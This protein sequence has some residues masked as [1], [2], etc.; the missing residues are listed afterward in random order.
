MVFFGLRLLTWMVA[1]GLAALVAASAQA[2]SPPD[3]NVFYSLIRTERAQSPPV[4][5]TK[6]AV[7]PD[8]GGV[9]RDGFFADAFVSD[10]TGQIVIAFRRLNPIP[11]VNGGTYDT[12][13]AILHGLAPRDYDRDVR[14]FVDAVSTVAAHQVPPLSIDPGNIFVT[15]NSL[16]AY[17]AQ[18]AAREFHYGGVGFAGPGI[19]GYHAPPERAGNFINYLIYG[20][21]VANHAADTGILWAGWSGTGSLGDHYG[22]IE[23]LGNRS[24]QIALQTA[25]SL[26][27]IG[28]VAANVG[29]AGFLG[30]GAEIGLWHMSPRYQ[31]RLHIETLPQRQTP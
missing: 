2:A 21:P 31:A 4:G 20:D 25:V 18:V 11:F 19:P 13:A 3:N 24:D 28:P 10:E 5:W 15:G 26:T 7:A 6:L 14:A 27:A 23:R 12:D 9:S 8:L 29:A 30:L 16:G 1:V 17:G 22:R